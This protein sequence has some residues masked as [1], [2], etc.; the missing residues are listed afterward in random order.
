MD[1]GSAGP[2]ARSLAL[3]R[4]VL[5]ISD[6]AAQHTTISYRPPELF[7][8]E[9]RVADIT[10][11]AT[12][13]KDIDGDDLFDRESVLDYRKVD[14]WMMGCTLFAILFGASPGECE[15][16]RSTGQLLIVVPSHNKMLGQMPPWPDEE[17]PSSRWYSSETKE[18]LEWILTK[19]RGDRPT[20]KQIRRKVRELLSQKPALFGR[21]GNGMLD[22]ESQMID[23]TF[24]TK[25]IM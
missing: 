2:L 5:E 17:T 21:D 13:T 20:V 1:Y 4:D 6:E 8:G 3:R 9:L 10:T 24:A 25:G 12:T 16:S 15:F 18:L 19:D 11:S 23:M 22:V 14:A 7:A